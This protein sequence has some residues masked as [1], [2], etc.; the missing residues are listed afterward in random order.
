MKKYI[1]AIGA[2]ILAAI[3]TQAQN[4]TNPVVWI[5]QT[6]FVAIPFGI[7]RMDT[8]DWGYGGAL[9][10]KV[11]DNFWTG[12]RVNNISGQQVSAGVQAQLQTTVAWSGLTVTPFIEASTGLGHDALYGSA[13]AG[14]LITFHTWNFNVVNHGFQA[15]VG[16]VGDYEHVIYGSQNWNQLCGGPLLCLSF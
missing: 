2:V 13:G 7:Y 14:G 1:I 8:K 15:S 10:Y 9:L 16:V 6:N 5:G 12:L 3:T 4:S 11:T